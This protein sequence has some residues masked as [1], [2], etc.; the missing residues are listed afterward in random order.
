M[1]KQKVIAIVLSLVMLLQT[2]AF[3]ETKVPENNW[4]EKDSEL[5]TKPTYYDRSPLEFTEIFSQINTHGENAN[6][7]PVNLKEQKGLIQQADEV[8]ADLSQH[9][10]ELSPE[11]QVIFNGLGVDKE[12][13]NQMLNI[14]NS[15]VLNGDAE[16]DITESKNEEKTEPSVEVLLSDPQL[17]ANNQL[18]LDNQLSIRGAAIEL[19]TPSIH[20]A[21]DNVAPVYNSKVTFS[22][23]LNSSTSPVTGNVNFTLYL[24]DIEIDTQNVTLNNGQASYTTKEL[25]IG[26]YKIAASYLG[27]TTFNQ[28]SSEIS[29]YVVKKAPGKITWPTASDVTYGQALKDSRLSGGNASGGGTFNWK[30]PLT[31]PSVVNSGYPV[32]FNPGDTE[33]YDYSTVDVE[34]IVNVDVHSKNVDMRG[35]TFSDETKTYDGSTKKAEIKGTLP[36]GITSVRYEANTG[37]NVGFYDATVYFTTDSNHNPVDPLHATLTIKKAVP[38]ITWPQSSEL[39]YGQSLKNAKLTGGNVT[40]GGTFKWVD[41]EQK[42]GVKNNGYEVELTPLDKENYDYTGINLI[43]KIDVNVIE[44]DID[45]S[46]LTFESKPFIYDG[47]EKSVTVNGNL[48]EGITNIRYENNKGINAGTYEAV[49]YF[50]V[51]GN[52]KAIQPMYTTMIINK[53]QP[54]IT[55]P[56]ATPIQYGQKLSDSVLTGGSASGGGTFVWSNANI[57]P[58]VNNIGYDVV[59]A[60]SDTNNYNY[61]NI[62]LVKTTSLVVNKGTIDVSKLTFDSYSVPYDGTEHSVLLKG[63]VPSGITNI[64]YDNHKGIKAGVYNATA[65]FEVDSNHEAIAPMSATLNINKAV[66]N[67]DGVQFES[68]SYPYDG[69]EKTVMV[70]GT[71]P[72]GV[73]RVAYENNRGKNVGIYD[74]KAI[75]II[76]SENYEAV[77]EKLATLAITAS[78]VDT[79]DFEYNM[80]NT[81]LTFDGEDHSIYVQNKQKQPITENLPEGITKIEYSCDNVVAK[82]TGNKV[83]VTESGVYNV[84]INYIT[85]ANH[86][87]IPENTT[88]ITINKAVSTISL[89]AKT[90][91]L[92]EGVN[93]EEV[94][95]DIV[96]FDGSNLEPEKPDSTYVNDSVLLEANI[97]GVSDKWV[98]VGE[99]IFKANDTEIGRVP[100]NGKNNVS[101]LIK[102]IKKG[103]FAFTVTYIGD[104]NYLNALAIVENYNVD[105]KDQTEL[106]IPEIKD[107][108]YGDES[109]NV[110]TSGGNSGVVKLSSKDKNIEINADMVSIVG[111]GQATIIATRE[112]DERYNPISSTPVSFKITKAIPIINKKPEATD[113]TVGQTLNDSILEKG[114]AIGVDGL[115]LKGTF[116]WNEPEKR[117]ANSG[118]FDTRYIPNDRDNYEE[119]KLT[120]TLTVNPLPEPPT[121]ITEVI[122]TILN[123]VTSL[124]NMSVPQFVL[125]FILF[126]AGALIIMNVI[127]RRTHRDKR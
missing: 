111:A 99:L 34:Q 50:T 27:S 9:Y 8:Y 20:L 110:M 74:A 66:V 30:D 7:D 64:K 21:A 94:P 89:N 67:M 56:Q 95:V 77:D 25:G 37:V 114:Q 124:K 98:P 55:W 4:A 112:G 47:N 31:L 72:K 119:V 76:D 93:D 57:T 118:V 48:P 127:D 102:N 68:K 53:A 92:N 106:T 45:I 115:G 116:V 35:I 1:K 61:T 58:N 49:A 46:N 109:F 65:T 5:T 104:D 123:P 3:A 78:K 62:N 17:A 2:T 36:T 28:V 12:A 86:Q 80:K 52:H 121:Q 22:A 44:S 96:K 122:Q 117:V 69:N 81:T 14:L 88:S 51:D 42:P 73:Q 15:S 97:F 63:I 59:F 41:G 13:L 10:D 84:K 71:L 39:T 100:I 126:V 91:P 90:I 26:T 32:V 70:T 83:I 79:E 11:N 113:I 101:F 18:S 24:N 23:A 33:N 108:I 75:F 29:N 125:I 40:G 43:K 103:D 16:M 38:S 6:L 54:T 19:E 82:V 107:K 60:P 87:P 120:S 85:D 105:K